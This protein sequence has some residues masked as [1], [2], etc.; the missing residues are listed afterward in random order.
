MLALENAPDNGEDGRVHV[1]VDPPAR[2][3]AGRENPLGK[4]RRNG[5]VHSSRTGRTNNRP[6]RHQGLVNKQGGAI[7]ARRKKKDQEG[8][9]ELR[10][11]DRAAEIEYRVMLARNLERNFG[12][13]F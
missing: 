11:N 5:S 7:M 6:G 3:L 4:G 1:P 9:I 8:P 10:E 2:K 12:F 13:G